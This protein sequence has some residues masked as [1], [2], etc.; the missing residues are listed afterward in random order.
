MQC[1]IGCL[2]P[3]QGSQVQTSSIIHGNLLFIIMAGNVIN[4]SCQ[5]KR[6]RLKRNS[7]FD[8]HSNPKS[9]EFDASSES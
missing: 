5:A 6:C 2:R 7:F 4:E 1:G 8:R 3:A 9:L